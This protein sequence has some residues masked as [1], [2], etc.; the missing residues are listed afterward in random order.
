MTSRDGDD[1]Q[2]AKA[3]SG[4]VAGEPPRREIN[5]NKPRD[6]NMK[7]GSKTT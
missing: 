3:P 1:Q 7:G 5:R 2:K 4:M 6:A